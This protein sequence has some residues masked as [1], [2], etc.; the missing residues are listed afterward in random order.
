M[1]NIQS[2]FPTQPL[3]SSSSLAQ[4]QRWAQSLNQLPCYWDSYNFSA[5]VFLNFYIIR[6]GKYIFTRT[7]WLQVSGRKVWLNVLFDFLKIFS[8]FQTLLSLTRH[9]VR[10]FPGCDFWVSS[11]DMI[12]HFSHMW[13]MPAA[14]HR[15][16][17]DTSPP[18]CC[19]S[20]PCGPHWVGFFL[21]FS[22]TSAC[23]FPRLLCSDEESSG[24]LAVIIIPGL[25]GLSTVLVV[26]LIF[27]N[28][29]KNKKRV[30]SMSTHSGTYCYDYEIFFSKK[31][32]KEFKVVV[33]EG[34]FHLWLCFFFNRPDCGFCQHSL[35]TP[36]GV[37]SWGTRVLAGGSLW[38]HL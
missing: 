12:W 11:V 37:C 29:H 25:L 10:L 28:L 18:M 32:L 1:I 9:R 30:Q 20:N 4:P 26:T 14:P 24:N 7:L 23:F 27:Y 38:P 19:K 15:C 3:R 2:T 33:F 21:L 13:K 17:N 34:V 5:A 35:G 36:W 6:S 16:G 8:H 31:S 22:Y